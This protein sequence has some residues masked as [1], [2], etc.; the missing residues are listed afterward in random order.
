MEDRVERESEPGYEAI[1]GVL[2]VLGVTVDL[3]MVFGCGGVKQLHHSVTRTHQDLHKKT[4]ESNKDGDLYSPQ[5][6]LPS[7]TP[8]TLPNSL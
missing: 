2:W 7:P 5:L 4:S 1:T 8:S 6:P 3:P